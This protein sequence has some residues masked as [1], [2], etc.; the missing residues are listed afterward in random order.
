L[1]LVHV[2]DEPMSHC[3]S[4]RVDA[5]VERAGMPLFNRTSAERRRN[6]ADV[7]LSSISKA[8]KR[9]GDREEQNSLLR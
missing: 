9:R 6:S 2:L 3:K 7:E 5:E 8:K 4:R 1:P